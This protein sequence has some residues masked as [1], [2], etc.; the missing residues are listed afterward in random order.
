MCTLHACMHACM[1]INSVTQQVCM[2]CSIWP[3]KHCILVVSHD[4]SLFAVL[5]FLLINLYCLYTLHCLSVPMMRH[6][7]D[8]NMIVTQGIT[9]HVTS[10]RSDLDDYADFHCAGIVFGCV[11]AIKLGG[12]VRDLVKPAFSSP[13]GTQYSWLFAYESCGKY[14]KNQQE[15]SICTERDHHQLPSSF[16]AQVHTDTAVCYKQMFAVD[17]PKLGQIQKRH[18]AKLQQACGLLHQATTA[19]LV[20]HTLTKKHAP[21]LD[22]GPSAYHATRVKNHLSKAKKVQVAGQTLAHQ[23]TSLQEMLQQA[24]QAR[25]EET[26]QVTPHRPLCLLP[27]HCTPIVPIAL[28]TLVKSY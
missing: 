5:A 6:Y 12:Q 25:L 11:S 7:F 26:G 17:M 10:G 14:G 15:C 21:G 13:N 28:P 23:V 18:V 8:L 20:R 24:C 9:T 22:L 1:Q 19:E 16:C 2:Y 3:A 4:P 27:G